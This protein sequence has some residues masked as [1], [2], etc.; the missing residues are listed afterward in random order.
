M[1]FVSTKSR[2]TVCWPCLTV[3]GV[4]PLVTTVT[5]TNS[6]SALFGQ[7]TLS[8]LFGPITPACLLIH[9]TKYTHTQDSGLTL[10]FTFAGYFAGSSA[11]VLV[12][13]KNQLLSVSGPGTGRTTTC[14]FVG[15]F[16]DASNDS[17]TRIE[18]A[19]SSRDACVDVQENWIQIIDKLHGDE[20]SA[21]CSRVGH[22]PLVDVAKGIAQH[23]RSERKALATLMDEKVAIKT[24]SR[25]PNAG[26]L[27]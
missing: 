12:S 16:V 6:T 14:A 5:T 4:L 1:R 27:C 13:Y 22:W 8:A 9:I 20:Q 26:A 23:A 15:C 21:V 24:A 2:T 19:V 18:I 10:S 17:A 7:I 25:M 3:Y 11:D